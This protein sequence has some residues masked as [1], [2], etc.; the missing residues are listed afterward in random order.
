MPYSNVLNAQKALVSSLS[1]C[2]PDIFHPWP[3]CGCVCACCFFRVPRQVYCSEML[4]ADFSSSYGQDRLRELFRPSLLCELDA[5][6]P[7]FSRNI[8]LH[9]KMI[10]WRLYPAM[11]Y[12]LETF[13]APHMNSQQKKCKHSYRTMRM[14]LKCMEQSIPH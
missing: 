9:L 7:Y 3:M 2:S 1:L 4:L 12:F 10:K 6:L 5:H 11:C 13:S 14:K 8:H